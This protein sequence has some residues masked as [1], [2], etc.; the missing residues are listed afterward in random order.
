MGRGLNSDIMAQLWVNEHFEGRKLKN[1][2]KIGVA[3][4]TVGVAEDSWWGSRPTNCRYRKLHPCVKG[5]CL[6]TINIVFIQLW[7]VPISHFKR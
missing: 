2:L 5:D 6:F 1:P 3:T 7:P 4:H